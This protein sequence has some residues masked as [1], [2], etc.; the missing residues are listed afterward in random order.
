[1]SRESSMHR[2][3]TITVSYDVYRGL[4]E[5]I[6]RGGISRFIKGLVRP[7]VIRDKTL[8]AEYREAALDEAAEA[9]AWDWI[10]ADLGEHPR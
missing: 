2:R 6:G 7:H 3:L 9:E 1:V 8:E 5:H 4:H 10:E